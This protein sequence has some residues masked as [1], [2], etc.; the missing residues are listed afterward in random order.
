MTYAAKNPVVPNTMEPR[1]SEYLHGKGIR[2]G[3]PISGTFELTARC[4]FDC[5]MCYVHLQNAAELL[6]RELTADQWLSI[7]REARD[8]GMMFLLLTGGE[9]LIRKDFPYLYTELV[10][11]GLLLSVNTNASLYTDEIRA[12]F[13]KYPPTRIN[14]TL[15][16]GSE[17]TYRRLCG[18][19]SFGRVVDNLKTMKEDG[20]QVR[21]N[22]SLTPYNV[23]DMEAIDAISRDLCL[24]AKAASYMYPPV[25]VEGRPG[26][27]AARFDPEEAGRVMAEWNAMRDTPE[28][29]IRRGELLREREAAGLTDTCADTEQEGVACRAGRCSFW[30]TWD[31]RMLPCGTMDIEASYPLRDGF[32]TAWDE[33]R[34]RTAAI[35]LPAECAA[36]PSRPNCGVCASIC[37]CES[38][39]FDRKPAYFCRMTDSLCRNTVRIADE[40]KKEKGL[41]P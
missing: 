29:S 7:A 4:N 36:C 35:R 18:N 12:L 22:V 40:I 14:V 5:K 20:L 3:L 23:G 10:K 33:V 26:E 31:G 39:Q 8:A 11:M 21:L 38:G 6:P 16:G 41:Q 19:P 24:Q 13:R 15:Y 32:R 37:K 27:N 17:D 2:L 1:L 28:A 30:M 34:A 25:R 9:P